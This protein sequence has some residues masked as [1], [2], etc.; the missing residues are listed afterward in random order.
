MKRLMVDGLYEPVQTI[1]DETIYFES[2]EALSVTILRLWFCGLKRLLYR[3]RKVRFF[4]LLKSLRADKSHPDAHWHRTPAPEPTEASGIFSPEV[5][6]QL[7]PSPQG[8]Q[9]DL[10]AAI[11]TT[12]EHL[13]DASFGRPSPD[14]AARIRAQVS[15]TVF[16]EDDED[17]TKAFL[18]QICPPDAGELNDEQRRKAV[19]DAVKFATFQT[20]K[21][22]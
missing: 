4:R 11:Q 21:M 19:G 6:A 13:D 15:D 9:P 10:L 8:P 16:T 5:S 20:M 17:S 7:Q 14:T 18:V 1:V 22:T 2:Q 12:F 3:D